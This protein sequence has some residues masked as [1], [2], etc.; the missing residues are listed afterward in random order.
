MNTRVKEIVEELIKKTDEGLVA[1]GKVGESISVGEFVEAY[2][3]VLMSGSVI[4][5]NIETL[6]FNPICEKR[7]S[8]GIQILN[9]NGDVT[10][11]GCR[12]ENKDG[13]D[14]LLKRLHRAAVENYAGGKGSITESN[15]DS[16]LAELK[17]L[18]EKQIKKKPAKLDIRQFNPCEEGLKYYESKASFKEAWDDCKDG[19]WM[20][21]IA[22][23]LKAPDSLMG[24]THNECSSTQ[25]F[26]IYGNGNGNIR[27]R[28][29]E[30]CR[31]YLSGFVLREVRRLESQS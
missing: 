12:E 24:R 15:F 22:S 21:W 25:N 30:I 6:H 14:S 1:W 29:A 16:I 11:G 17:P 2:K 5:T 18:P 10:Y 4:S 23:K 8:F 9:K 26:H 3:C 13:Y 28:N 7:H 31:D 19:D 20:I 27:E